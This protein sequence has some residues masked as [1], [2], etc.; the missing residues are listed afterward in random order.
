VR[1]LTDVSQEAD[2]AL[3]LIRGDALFR[4][5]RRIGLVPE[6]GLGVGRRALAL[7][8]FSWLPIAASALLAGRALPGE[9]AEPLLQHFGV[10]VRCLVAI[11]LFVLAEGVAHG[12]TT[13]LLPHFVRSGLVPEV[14]LPRFREILVEVARLRDRT[15]PW[16][17]ILGLVVASQALAAS[18]R[19]E[20]LW[21]EGGAP[22]VGFGGWWFAWVTRP[23]FMALLLGW[24]W[25]LV[26]LCVLFRRISALDLSLVPTHPD[27]AAGLGFMEKVPTLFSP[28]VL[29]VSA[30]F[31][32]R[33]AHDVLYHGVHVDS[34]RLQMGAVVVLSLLIFLAPLL[35]WLGPLA[36]A[37]RNALLDYGTLVGEHGRLV[38]ERWILRRKVAD[39]ALLGAQEIGPVA[40]TVT[41]YDAVRKQRVVPI[42]VPS[43]L[44]IALAAAL[45][46]LPVLAIEIPIRDLLLTLLK[47]LA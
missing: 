47:T 16:V 13:R 21:M 20:L 29:G 44:A 30:V 4:L 14:E 33:W 36:A 45:P 1:E 7:A 22:A 27:R 46:M 12:L 41:L 42:G 24:I 39:D 5:Q 37:K 43:L 25:R 18:D 26:L 40:D 19:H 23:I 17:A 15:L 31:A 8:L 10:Q 34:L 6:G 38:R 32:S 28:V 2:L 3:S 35:L 11:P 9:A